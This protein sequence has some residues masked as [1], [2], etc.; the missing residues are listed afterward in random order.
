MINAVAFLAILLTGA[1]SV[2]ELWKFR[3]L[4]PLFYFIIFSTFLAA[5]SALEI[6][7]D[8]IEDKKHLALIALYQVSITLYVVFFFN[9][10]RAALQTENWLARNWKEVKP[11]AALKIWVL[12]FVS[13]AISII[14]YIIFVGYNLFSFAIMQSETDFTAL[15]LNAYA[16]DAYTG[17]G[18]INP[19]KNT[20][21]PI[22][23][24]SIGFILARKQKNLALVAFLG[25]FFP[26]YIWIILG[27]GQRTF[28]FYNLVCFF[29]FMSH[30]GGMSAVFVVLAGLAFLW[31]FGM[32]SVLLGRTGDASILGAADQLYHRVF[33][34][35]LYGSVHG[36]RYVSNLPIQWGVEWLRVLQGLVPGQAGSSLSYE[37]HD[38]LFRSRRGTVP[39]TLWVSIYHNFGFIFVPLVMF[40]IL[41]LVEKARSL[42]I[43]LPKDEFSVFVSS[44]T[45]F[46]IGLV[47]LSN[48]FQIL[49]NGLIGILIIFLFFFTKIKGAA[50]GRR[51][52]V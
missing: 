10:Q 33:R 42:L 5:G 34:A 28:L 4:N 50:D 24:A 30:R 15:R 44:F 3:Q 39:V 41:L 11:E 36:F 27:T 46:Y 17:A 16:G 20:I 22:S 21:F 51:V 38:Y 29:I 9:R 45:C 52:A 32:Y 14:Y 1:V 49:N 35:N 31:L 13:A 25:I 48:P 47:P 19:F 26:L 6:N 43:S 12:L 23:F 18:L 8:R 37:V 2:R 40:S 7:F